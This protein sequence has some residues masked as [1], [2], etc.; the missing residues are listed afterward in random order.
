[1]ANLKGSE[2]STYV[3]HM[4]A[5]I[6]PR[7][8]LLNRLMTFGQDKGWRADT[9]ACLEIKPGDLVLDNGCGTGDLALEILAKHPSCR[10][11]ASDLTP[12]MVAVARRRP[13]A[14]KIDWVIA[15]SQRLPFA[16]SS[17]NGVVSGYLLRNLPDASG[18]LNEQVRVISRGG[19]MAALDT[20]PPR[21]MLAPFIRFYLRFIIPALGR[22]IAGDGEAYTYLPQSTEQ[23]LSAEKLASRME[24]A[25]FENVSFARRMFGTMAIHYGR[26]PGSPPSANPAP[27]SSA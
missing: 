27:K 10:I 14:A 26:K 2:R 15:D 13:K 23:F 4:F 18:G 8:D 5:R 12:E 17:F 21:G 19:R 1:M 20:T 6:A 16:D 22:A 9:V 25:G 7:Y 11:I 3:R 24:E